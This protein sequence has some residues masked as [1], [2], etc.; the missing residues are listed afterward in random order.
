VCRCKEK[1]SAENESAALDDVPATVHEQNHNCKLTSLKKQMAQ[2]SKVRNKQQR[3]ALLQQ[4]NALLADMSD[5]PAKKNKKKIIEEDPEAGLAEL[6]VDAFVTGEL[7]IYAPKPKPKKTA[8]D[9]ELDRML[10][11][12]TRYRQTIPCD[13]LHHSNVPSHLL[14]LALQVYALVGR[15][16][17]VLY[18]DLASEITSSMFEFERYL[19]VK[20]VNHVIVPRGEHHRHIRGSSLHSG[21][22]FGRIRTGEGSSGGRKRGVV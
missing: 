18:S 17:K 22:E 10:A 14:P 20:G 13:Y 9:D 3:E 15:P 5:A 8:Q 16:L 19:L 6:T 11:G 12:C 7:S 4:P 21:I 1:S 2:M